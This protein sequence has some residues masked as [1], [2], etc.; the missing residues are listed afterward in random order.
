VK[1]KSKEIKHSKRKRGLMEN[2]KTELDAQIL[3][4]TIDNLVD[5]YITIN[6]KGIIQSI[7]I[8]VEKMFGYSSQETMGQNIKMLMPDP[9]HSQHDQ[10]LKN[11]LTTGNAKI[12][13]MGRE[14]TGL[15]K[16]GETFPLD[17]SI[18][19]VNTPDGS[20]FV[21]IIRDITIKRQEEERKRKQ[22]ALILEMSTPVMNLWDD[23]LLL[24]LVGL[25]DS[26]RVQLIMEAVLQK[27]SDN[28]AK[29]IILDIQG[30]PTV[31]SAVANHLIKVTKATKLMGCKCVITGISPEIS[32]ALV[33]LGIELTDITTQ[34]TLKDGLKFAFEFLSLYVKENNESVRKFRS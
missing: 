26:K 3:Q 20:I 13:G 12:I 11:Y 23:I 32:Q 24:P 31:D 1:I 9:D 18:G 10:Y 5:G 22:L 25:V 21:G 8:A 16:N 6:E 27:I 14:V 33:N 15:K 29:V 7:N 30:V 4:A 28:Q 17:L 34:S 19:E 2:K